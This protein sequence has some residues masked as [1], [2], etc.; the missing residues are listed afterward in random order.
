VADVT[1]YLVG[2]AVDSRGRTGG[3]DGG[4]AGE[5]EKLANPVAG[6]ARAVSVEED[7]AAGLK[8][9]ADRDARGIGKVGQA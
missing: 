4:A 6:L 7:L 2:E 3:A 5:G 9:D 1:G 8:R